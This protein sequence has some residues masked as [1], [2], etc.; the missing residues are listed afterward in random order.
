MMV[1][2]AERVRDEARRMRRL[3]AHHAVTSALASSMTMDEAGPR[4]LDAICDSLGWDVGA[5]WRVDAA[6]GVIR[7]VEVRCPARFG[8]AD[9]EEASR[10]MAFPPGLGFPGRIWS[11]GEPSWVADVREDANFVRAHVAAQDGLRAAVGFPLIVRDDV[12]GVVE[13]LTEEIRPPDEELLKMMRAIGSQVGQFIERTEAEAAVRESEARKGAMLES[14]LDCVIA[15]DHDGR[16]TEFNPAAERTFGFLR[17][18]VLGERMV[19][20]I[21]A[22]ALRDAHRTGFARYLATG[23]SRVLGKRVEMLAIRADGTEFPVELAITRVSLPGPPAF[24]AYVRDIGERRR[25]E[26]ELRRSQE[27]YRWWSRTRRT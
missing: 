26:D 21:V 23:E 22:P 27:L 12:L 19:D 17:E 4:I 2:T 3:L 11:S 13:F 15:I 5:L 8:F 24:T 1:E 6:S 14:A 9:F 7:C 16:V 18:H 10:Q 20:L 25:G